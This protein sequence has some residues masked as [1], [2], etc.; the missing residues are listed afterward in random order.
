LNDYLKLV[1]EACEINKPITHHI[2][3]HTYATRLLNRGVGLDVIKHA[4]GH[5]SVNTTRIYAKMQDSTI[6]DRIL[7]VLNN[8]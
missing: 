3:R 4:M 7:N 8:E 6:N 5:K 1:G 2:A